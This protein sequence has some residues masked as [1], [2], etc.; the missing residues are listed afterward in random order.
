MNLSDLEH[1]QTK[2]NTAKFLIFWKLETAIEKDQ[3]GV[4]K[5]VEDFFLQTR[6]KD[7]LSTQHTNFIGAESHIPDL[8]TL[9]REKNDVVTVNLG[10]SSYR[11]IHNI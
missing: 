8:A 6:P 2:K 9:W 4:Q 7:I 1:V 3:N 10:H 5:M 11:F